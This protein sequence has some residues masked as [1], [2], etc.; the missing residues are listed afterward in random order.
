[1]KRKSLDVTFARALQGKPLT[2]GALGE[3]SATQKSCN[4][5]GSAAWTMRAVISAVYKANATVTL[6]AS[7]RGSDA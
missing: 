5:S 7:T 4:G 6:Q 1:V 2:R 3:R